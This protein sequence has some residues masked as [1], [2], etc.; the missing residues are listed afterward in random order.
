[1]LYGSILYF[2]PNRS[3]NTETSTSTSLK[4]KNFDSKI[5]KKDQIFFIR[6]IE[7]YISKN[8][9]FSTQIKINNNSILV[10]LEGKFKDFINFILFI[11]KHLVIKKID[12]TYINNKLSANILFKTKY[13]YNPNSLKQIVSNTD[14]PNIFRP[15][16][17]QNR[18]KPFKQFN[19]STIFD[20]TVCINNKFYKLYDNIGEYK[21][22]KI[23]LKSVI[24]NNKDKNITLKVDDD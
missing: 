11:E 3:K 19:L 4:I 18:T 16:K 6:Y 13:L 5:I 20:K 22:I 17:D 2:Y 21:I 23:D 14:I 24:L 7:K 1:M 12:I 8:H 15:I 9:L 10:S